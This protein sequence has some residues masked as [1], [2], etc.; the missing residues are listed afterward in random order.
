MIDDVLRVEVTAGSRKMHQKSEI[1]VGP[2]CGA[3]PF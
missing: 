2:S 1:E 3:F